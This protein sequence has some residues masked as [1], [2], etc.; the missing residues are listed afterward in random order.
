MAVEAMAA[1]MAA[2]TVAVAMA[3]VMVAFLLPRQRS[4]GRRASRMPRNSRIHYHCCPTP[5]PAD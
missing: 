2:V 5:R 1:E 4:S 3:V